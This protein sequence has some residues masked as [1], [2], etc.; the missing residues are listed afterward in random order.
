[1][2]L[3]PTSVEDIKAAHFPSRKSAFECIQLYHG[4]LRP[5]R[6]LK[7][8]QE[9]VGSR[10]TYR[11][12]DDDCSVRVS[13][14]SVSRCGQTYW[15]VCERKDVLENWNHSVSCESVVSLSCRT[16]AHVLCDIDANCNR[17]LIYKAREYGINIGGSQSFES[18]I[19]SKHFKA[20]SRL[21]YHISN[22]KN[23]IMDEQI[24]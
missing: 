15:I 3:S 21:Q 5:P 24:N 22:I 14:K 12:V 1:M 6:K 13:I 10:V 23:E 16:A 17:D 7:S 20:A 18:D 4:K 9:N 11:C 19:S 2:N 8:I